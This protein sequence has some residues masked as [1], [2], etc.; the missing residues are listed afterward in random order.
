MIRA[1]FSSAFLVASLAG[2]ALSGQALA[3]SFNIDFNVASGSGAGAP[4]STFGAASGQTGTWNAVTPVSTVGGATQ[5]LTNTAGLGTGALMTHTATSGSATGA[6][7][8]SDFSRLMADYAE[9]FGNNGQA[10]AEFTNLQTGVY[11]VWVYASLP[12]ADATYLDSF[13][14]VTPHTNNLSVSVNNVVQ[15]F[16]TTQGVAAGAFQ[17][18]LTHG[19]F[20]VA[21]TSAAQAMRVLV[22]PDSTY[23]A[24]RSALNGIQ[25]ERWTSPRI[26]VDWSATGAATGRDW[27]NAM[28]SLQEALDLATKSNGVV[29]EI[30][31]ADGTY[32][33]GNSR[34]QS[35][36]IPSGVKLYGS[37][38]GGESSINERDF[39]NGP[40]TT[41]S[42]ALGNP[43]D[44]SDDSYHVVEASNTNSS[45][46]LDGFIIYEG[47]ATGTGDDAR[48]AGLFGINADLTV[49]NCSFNYNKASE[50]GAVYLGAGSS[51]RFVKTR[52]LRNV[53]TQFGGGVRN[54]SELSIGFANCTF[55]ENEAEFNGGAINSTGS[56]L[57]VHN[58]VFKGNTASQF[59]GA[60]YVFGSG[61]DSIFR[62]CSF[63]F[64]RGVG[65]TY[66]GIG[67]G[68]AASATVHNSVFWTNLDANTGTS[69]LQ[70][71]IGGPTGTTVSVSDSILE[72]ATILFG[73]RNLGVN[74]GF[75]DQFGPNNI[76]GDFD[77]D[78]RPAPGSPMI[79]SGNNASMPTDQYDVDFDGNTGE[80]LP[81]DLLDQDRRRDDPLKADTGLGT[82]PIVDR[83]AYEFQPQCRADFNNDG[84]VDFF[85]YLDFAQAYSTEDPTADFNTD[86]QVDFFDY[87]DF[88]QAY[89]A[90]C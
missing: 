73:T 62:N 42:G 56:F 9:V 43:A 27:T 45:T 19:V 87:L 10:W 33:P 16:Q 55:Q 64:N 49:A 26:Y 38:S 70:E 75:V 81:L 40:R 24:A 48:G 30:W 90:G 88:A 8:T 25:L 20:N 37:F 47:D 79:D 82:A 61:A 80:L 84:Q 32:K 4:T 21:I 83:G 44:D 58:S 22:L 86:G 28:T 36:V 60:V 53:A 50:G 17:R 39:S 41:L 5:A 2:S 14:F 52:F 15:G 34:S 1:S 67:L 65:G 29:Q 11:R 68:S 23:F 13:N 3:Q 77:D 76:A 59:G 54:V 63:S 69:T 71:Q 35:F 12:P 57:I 72:G 31:V 85:D 18:G 51:A 66:G 6:H 74:P 78:L 7:G 89:D 46:R